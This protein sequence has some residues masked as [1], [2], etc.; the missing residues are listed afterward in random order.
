MLGLVASEMSGGYRHMKIEFP[1]RASNGGRTLN[2]RMTPTLGA[3]GQWVNPRT[4]PSQDLEALPSDPS[5]G[6]TNA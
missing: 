5:Q 1:F 6:K 3:T 4:P 2:E